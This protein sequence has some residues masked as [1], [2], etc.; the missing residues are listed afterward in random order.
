MKKLRNML[1]AGI[2]ALTTSISAM[3]A[4]P[5]SYAGRQLPNMATENAVE[6]VNYSSPSYFSDKQGNVF[7]FYKIYSF[8]DGY[9]F[10]NKD[11]SYSFCKGVV[12]K[13]YKGEERPQYVMD[14]RREDLNTWDEEGTFEFEGKE[15]PYSIVPPAQRIYSDCQGILL[16]IVHGI[17][18]TAD[19]IACYD[20]DKDGK[21]DIRDSILFVKDYY[22]LPTNFVTNLSYYGD[23]FKRMDLDDFLGI[24]DYHYQNGEDE[25][26]I[27]Y[28]DTIP[29]ATT[30]ISTEMKPAPTEV[31]G[32]VTELEAVA[33]VE[34][35][36]KTE[37]VAENEAKAETATETTSTSLNA[38]A[39]LAEDT[40]YLCY[41]AV[42]A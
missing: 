11:L 3:S 23:S 32:N 36:G 16:M 30:D 37:A 10:T 27:R 9:E 28:G 19:D 25:I 14:L 40:V 18:C 17:P 4:I 39:Q 20:V 31:A 41:A 15:Y 13:P 6:Y 2:I 38:V 8:E 7:E 12:C 21:I 42:I 24:L 1:T 33:E 29:E 35:E 22:A 34:T 5:T 26:W